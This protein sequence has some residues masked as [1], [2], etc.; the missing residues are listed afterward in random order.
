LSLG[1][2]LVEI[3]HESFDDIGIE[4]EFVLTGVRLC[5]KLVPVGVSVS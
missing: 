3:L 5:V 2:C 1:Q 4:D